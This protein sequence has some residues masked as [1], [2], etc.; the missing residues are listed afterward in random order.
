[1]KTTDKENDMLNWFGKRLRYMQEVKRDE[2]GFT[3][4]EL[5]V[6]VI[7]IGILAAIAIPTFLAQRNKSY[8][9]AATSDVRN[10]ATLAESIAVD[11]N[12]SYSTV[13]AATLN[14]AGQKNSSGTSNFAAGGTATDYSISIKSKSGDTCRYVKSASPQVGCGTSAPSVPA[15][16]TES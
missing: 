14:T 4:I 11:N 5:L 3:L 2:R 7:I 9:A 13:T 15:G 8:N 16:I 12:G 6:V 1:M 10:A